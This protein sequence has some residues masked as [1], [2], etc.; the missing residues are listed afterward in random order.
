M[1]LL[2]LL[3]VCLAGGI[4]GGKNWDLHQALKA[5]NTQKTD[6]L[7]SSLGNA[8]ITRLRGPGKDPPKGCAIYLITYGDENQQMVDFFDDMIQV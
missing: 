7:V 1:R 5:D 3:N 4:E 6:S 2:L 8:P